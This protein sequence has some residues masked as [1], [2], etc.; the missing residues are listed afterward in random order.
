MNDYFVNVGRKLN[1]KIDNCQ[2]SQ[3]NHMTSKA[4]SFFFQIIVPIEVFQEISCL[5]AKKSPGPE[6][7]PIKFSKTFNEKIS[8]FHSVLYNK[9]VEIGHF[10]YSL[11][12]AK[13]NLHQK[14]Y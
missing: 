7:I 11:K 13:N 10:P 5:N 12:L 1:A 14:Q 4:K 6:N 8:N 9:F 2:K 3:N